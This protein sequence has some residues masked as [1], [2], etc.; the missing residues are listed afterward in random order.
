MV[1]RDD[2][3]VTLRLLDDPRR[4]YLRSD[5][6][7]SREDTLLLC[8]RVLLSRRLRD[9]G[10]SD[11]ALLDSEVMAEMASMRDELERDIRDS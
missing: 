9:K 4:L 1:A 3:L 5:L 2:L 7:A 8:L 10:R 6:D 11:N